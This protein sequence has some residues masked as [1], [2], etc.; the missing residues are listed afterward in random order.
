VDPGVPVPATLFN[1]GKAAAA[2]VVIT[3][4]ERDDGATMA[5]R[6]TAPERLKPLTVSAENVNVPGASG[7]LKDQLPPAYTGTSSGC[8]PAT[9]MRTFE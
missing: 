1:S 4:A 8:W 7:A 6:G 9:V 3:G 2:D 5:V